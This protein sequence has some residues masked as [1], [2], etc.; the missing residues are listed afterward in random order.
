MCVSPHVCLL[1]L[2][3]DGFYL[4]ISLQSILFPNECLFDIGTHTTGC[5]RRQTPPS[6]VRSKKLPCAM[7]SAQLPEQRMGHFPQLF[8]CKS[9]KWGT[10]I[11]GD[12]GKL[13][14]WREVSIL[15]PLALIEVLQVHG[16][17]S[18]LAEVLHRNETNPFSFP[19]AIFLF[20]SSEEDKYRHF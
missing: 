17:A 1:H 16:F 18:S 5:S 11:L 19:C 7:S 20:F 4:H 10:L 8:T 9:Q 3:A 6:W 15:V 2:L 12:K 14:K 13:W